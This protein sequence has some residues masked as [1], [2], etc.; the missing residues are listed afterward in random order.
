MKSKD[1]IILRKILE[2]CKQAE[3]ACQ[4]FHNEYEH[5]LRI[6]VLPSKSLRRS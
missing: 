1:V 4:M 3:E 2:Y 6:S 5:L